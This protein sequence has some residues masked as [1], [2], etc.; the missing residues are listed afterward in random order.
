MFKNRSFLVKLVNDK[1]APQEEPVE[2]TIDLAK[3]KNHF[4][5]NA[6]AYVI[7]AGFTYHIMRG[8]HAVVGNAASDGSETITVRP[9]SFFSKQTNNVIAVIEREGRGHPGYITRC[10]ETNKD[11]PTQGKAANAYGINR[12]V[13][14]RHVNGLIDNANGLHFERLVGVPV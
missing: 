13:M 7:L 12:T 2:E 4:I 9:L 14:S 11:F 8:R 1:D 6:P 5:R 3:I 10:I